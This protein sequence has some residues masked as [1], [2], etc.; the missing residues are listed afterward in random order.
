M[1]FALYDAASAGTLKWN[2][3]RETTNRVQVTGGL[4][5]VK[6]GDVAAFTDPTIFSGGALYF[7]ITLANPATAT[8]STADCQTWESAMNRN[9]L[10]TSAY[11]FNS[12]LLDGIDSSGFIQ[13]QTGSTQT[14][15]FKISG[16]GTLSTLNASTSISLGTASTTTG[17][18]VMNNGTNANTV[19]LRSGVTTTSYTMTLPTAVGASGD[20]MKT[21]DASGTLT[22]GAC[23]A[24]GGVTTVGALDGGTAN[25][26]GATITGTSI[27]LQSASAS[28]SGL[29]NTTTQTFTGAKTFNDGISLGVASTTNGSMVLKNSANANTA[30]IQSGATSTSYTLT[31]PTALGASGDCLKDTTGTGVLGFGACAT[32]GGSTLQQAYDL[33]TGPELTLDS[34]RGGL[35]VRDNATPITGN[36]LEVQNNAGNATFLG[37]TTSAMTLQD[38]SANTAMLFDST[39]SELRIYENVASPSRYVR[40]YYDTAANAAVFAASSGSTQIGVAGTGGDITMNLNGAAAD[41]LAANKTFTS[42]ANYSGSDFNFTRNLQGST[43]ALTGNVFKIE[44]LS[45]TTSGSSAPNVLYINQNNTS[46]TGNLILAQTGGSVDKFKVDMSGNTTAAGNITSGGTISSTGNITSGGNVSIA[47]GSSYT[48][49]GAVTLSSASGSNLTLQASNALMLFD[50]TNSRITLGAADTTGVLLVLDTKTSAGDPTGT[51]GG[52]YYNSSRGK[53]RCY[54]NGAWRDCIQD[55]TAKITTDV[56]NNNATANTLQ[57]VTG[58]SFAVKAGVTYRFE[59]LIPYNSAAT[60]TGSRW[61]LNG[62]AA[63]LLSYKSKYTLTATT[64]T[65]NFANAYSIPAASNASSLASTANVATIEGMITPSADGTVQVQ[66]ASEIANSAITAKAGGTLMWWEVY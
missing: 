48:G 58:L 52:M 41:K 12:E 20:C 30:T 2:E 43:Y 56:V 66:F 27:F 32:G 47:A 38:A 29:V 21:S 13:N 37:L 23:A 5:N 17:T 44:D 33:S 54:E 36:L 39:N 49:A 7:E 22:F 42:A 45:T 9:Q 16:A 64:E 59:V 24:G 31:L 46:A 6:L 4:F 15:D 18:M 63:T 61:T 25:A 57:D 26:N 60:N 19:T 40:M 65:T 11:A 8:C 55:N 35:T 14:A 34:T 53:F 10:A 51:N 50:S 1:K 28:Y 3:T 62:P